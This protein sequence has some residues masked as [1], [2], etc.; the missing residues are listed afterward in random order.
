MISR[1]TP[2]ALALA[3]AGCAIG[4]DYQRPATTL[5]ENY[6][7]AGQTTAA[8]AVN[9]RWWTLFADATLNDLVDQALKNNADVRLAIARIEQAEAVARE[10]GSLYFPEIDVE[11]GSSNSQLSSKTATWN[12]AMPRISHSRRAALTTSYEFDVW[13]SARRANEA[14]RA[15]L[16]A[17]R[18]SRDTIGLTIA[19][20]VS[21]AYL[22]LRAL[23]AQQTVAAESLRDN[24][25]NQKLV[26][27]RLDAGY[28]SPLD[29]HQA[30]SAVAN[31]EA[32][33][34]ELK[35]Q[36]ALL[37]HQLALLTA[38]PSLTIAAGDLRQLP[39]PPVP[40]AGLPADLIEARP[41]VRQAEQNLI[42][43]NA[44]IGIAKAGYF[45]RFSLTGSFGSESA[46]L[47][48]LFTAGAE[49]WSFGLGLFAPLLDFGRTTARVD[50]AV[51]VNEQSLIAW[52]NSLQIAY[53]EVRDALVNLRQNAAAESARNAVVADT[54]EAL[55]IYNRRYSEGYSSYLEVLLA[56][57]A[58]NS[59]L[60]NLIS[61]RQARLT[62]AVDLFKAL[63]GGWN[64]RDQESGIGNQ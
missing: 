39:L 10:T 33:L 54:K 44:N 47:N 29:L 34:A 23:D 59:A 49:T 1:L 18:Y 61:T 14:A 42:A 25:A 53:K 26:K 51:A 28:V 7:E 24:E 15:N 16:L 20:L 27:A 6:P 50:Q 38:N 64:G 36:R 37:E 12:A 31:A 5:P 58:Y 48:N 32:Q 13:G 30:N 41:D 9:N 43:A 62:A 2:L 3:L 60:A 8:A 4:P 63:G 57:N 11:A 19:A 21:N 46:T 45:P 35:R 40:P 22:A 52:Q 55:R 17:S 56:Q